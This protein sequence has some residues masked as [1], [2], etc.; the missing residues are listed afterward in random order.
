MLKSLDTE[1]QNREAEE[2]TIGAVLIDPSL[3][4]QIAGLTISRTTLTGGYGKLLAHWFQNKLRLTRLQFA[5][6]L[7]AVED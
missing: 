3:H 6:N 4:Y 2:A 7:K 1:P 5:M